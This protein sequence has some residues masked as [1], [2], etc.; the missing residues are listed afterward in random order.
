MC[1]NVVHILGHKE[2]KSG[3]KYFLLN[4]LNYKGLCHTFHP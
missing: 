4:D 1:L 2:L 3:G